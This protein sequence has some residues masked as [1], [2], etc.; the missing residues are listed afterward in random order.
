[1]GDGA[2]EQGRQAGRSRLLHLGFNRSPVCRARSSWQRRSY[3]SLDSGL[4]ACWVTSG[5]T[6]GMCRESSHAAAA[7]LRSLLGP[8]AAACFCLP[9]TD[10]WHEVGASP[11]GQPRA[12]V[13]ATM[14]FCPSVTGQAAAFQPN[15]LSERGR[16][17]PLVPAPAAALLSPGITGPGTN[18]CA[19]L[20]PKAPVRHG[21]SSQRH[22]TCPQPAS[23]PQ[24]A[25]RLQPV[26]LMQPREGRGEGECRAVCQS[27]ADMPDS[28]LH[29]KIIPP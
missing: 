23:F 7:S 12:H 22:A 19:Q 24:T 4:S 11:R 10:E 21:S 29:V 16:R 15:H 2:A 8:A 20:N 3:Q 5:V 1:M 18:N 28:V 17:R 6:R 14:M 13:E 26:L 25:P 9:A 27:V